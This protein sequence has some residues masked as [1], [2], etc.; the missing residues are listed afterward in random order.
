MAA[1]Q[2]IATRRLPA[3]G[4][5]AG[6]LATRRAALGVLKGVA[7]ALAVY[8]AVVAHEAIAVKRAAAAGELAAARAREEVGE[9]RLSEAA[10]SLARARSFFE[11]AQRRSA[12]LRVLLAPAPAADALVA[13]AR[14]AQTL[15]A[16]AAGAAGAT[17]V[18]VDKAS[19]VAA[20]R[21]GPGMLAAL[22]ELRRAMT[23]ALATLDGD[24]ARL[25]VMR[26]G[27]LA[28]PLRDAA[29]R[30]R[31]RLRDARAELA[32]GAPALDALIVFAGGD[33]PRRYLVL[34]QNPDEPRPT[35]GFIGTYGVFTARSGRV[36]LRRYAPIERWY[37]GR[38]RALVAPA[39]APHALRLLPRKP[40][41]QTLANVNASPDW[42][43]AARLAARLWRAG[44]EAPVDGVISLTPDLVAR[45]QR[46]LGPVRVPG[47]RRAVTGA[48]VVGLLD[49]LTHR[50]R[51]S[52]ARSRKHFVSQL[53]RAIAR[54]LSSGRLAVAALARAVTRGLNEGEGVAW[55]RDPA[56]QRALVARGWDGT[57]PAV[58]G[59]FLYDSEFSAAAKNG[60]DLR[61][62][63]DH[64]VVLHADG[65]AR[66]T[67]TITVRNASRLGYPYRS[68]I[69][70]YG[71][72]GARLLRGSEPPIAAERPLAGHPAAGWLRG[73]IAWS[74]AS[75]RVVWDVPHMLVR[76]RDGSFVYR[77][78]FMR[79]AAHRGDRLRLRVVAPRGWRW[80][81]RGP[82]ERWRLDRDVRGA[83]RL[84]GRR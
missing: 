17:A 79:V 62:R 30:A 45:V 58:R 71:P 54:R 34:S 51:H 8:A 16:V 77:L 25:Q 29:R 73:A 59:D 39:R 65:S 19:V 64:R 33:G 78:T 6:R 10:A 3:V 11:R 60:R 49:R 36:Q 66:V 83:W 48:N 35:G 82:R 21:P 55:S 5:G 27:G 74:T 75:L 15:S 40:A 80:A 2:P 57:L 22:R 76:R 68:Y 42:P 72:R 18:V 38:R 24:E 32:S 61:R 7:V 28:G 47:Y 56:V 41:P 12:M 26:A 44:G 50:T 20:Q 4:R 53:A 67:T 70:L 14:G 23:G 1:C 69:V 31:L 81:H 52:G 37:R 63:F 43:R 13:Q 84:V 9:G 46:V